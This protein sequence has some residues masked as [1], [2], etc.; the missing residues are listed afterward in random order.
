MSLIKDK[1]LDPA[2]RFPIF[3]IQSYTGCPP[4]QKKKQNKQRPTF[5]SM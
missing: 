4:P 5:D 3:S 1:V 2:K